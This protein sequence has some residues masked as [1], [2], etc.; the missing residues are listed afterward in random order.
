M[1]KFWF[2][3]ILVILL[4]LSDVY[5]ADFSDFYFILLESQ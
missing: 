3:L 2:C 5:S 1:L 4:H